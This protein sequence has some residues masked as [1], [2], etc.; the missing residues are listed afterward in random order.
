MFC[1]VTL[2]IPYIYS[3]IN[4]FF[5]SK[6][7]RPDTSFLW[8]TNPCKTMK[9]IVWRRFKWLFIGLIILLIILLFVA[10]LLYSLPVRIFSVL[11]LFSC[12]VRLAFMSVNSIHPFP[13]TRNSNQLNSS[14]EIGILIPVNSSNGFL[15]IKK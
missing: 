13:P 1:W 8:F 3:T 11:L 10:V 14:R 12:S 2:T 7:S 6:C 15:M 4:I 9:F 5:L